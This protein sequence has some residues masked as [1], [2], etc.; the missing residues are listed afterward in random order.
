MPTTTTTIRVDAET[1]RQLQELGETLGVSLME[2]VRAAT[3][4][5]RRQRFGQKVADELAA[6]QKD[7]SQ[8]SEYLA[9]AE[10]TTVGDGLD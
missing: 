9:D 10:S 1:H 5:L 2:T 8:W 3:E 6:L 7:P 4:A